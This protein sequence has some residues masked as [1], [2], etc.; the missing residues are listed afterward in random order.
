MA[1]ILT[2]LA[3]VV[4][5]QDV[6]PRGGKPQ[7]QQQG[8]QSQQQDKKQKPVKVALSDLNLQDDSIP[9]SLLHP[10]W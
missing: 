9:D 1:G 2:M 5:P 4:V 10:R 3:M 8:S 7:T 6:R